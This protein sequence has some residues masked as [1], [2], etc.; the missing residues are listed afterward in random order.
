MTHERF[1]KQ[2]LKSVHL[3]AALCSFWLFERMQYL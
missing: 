3:S 1:G 2:I